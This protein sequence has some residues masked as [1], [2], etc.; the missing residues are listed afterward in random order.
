MSHAL[1]VTH[2]VMPGHEAEFDALVERTV[3]GVRQH[4]PGTLV[5]V[6]HTDAADPALRVFYELY[7]DREAFEAHEQ[8]EHVRTFLAERPQHVSSVAV[9]TLE[10]VAG[11]TPSR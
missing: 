10:A 9:A 1:V 7:R 4:E 2:V 6:S 5:Y 3:A 8:Q 11:V